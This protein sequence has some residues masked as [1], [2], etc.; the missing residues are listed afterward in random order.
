MKFLFVRAAFV[1]PIHDMIVSQLVPNAKSRFVLIVIMRV[2]MV[3]KVMAPSINAM[4]V[5]TLNFAVNAGKVVT[6]WFART[7][8]NTFH[9]KIAPMTFLM[10]LE[11]NMYDAS[12]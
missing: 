4:G 2:V 7:V 10:T 1:G 3:T 9:A 12:F 11:S 6:H 5:P 8:S